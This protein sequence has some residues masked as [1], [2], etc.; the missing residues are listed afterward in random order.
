MNNIENMDIVKRINKL[1]KEKNAVIL[2]H[3]YQPEEIQRIAD[4]IGDSLELCIKAE[5][6]DADIIVFCGVDFMAETAKILNE[7]KKVLM[8]EIKDT[9]CPMAHQ[10][11]PETIINAKTEH[12]NA[13]VV[14]YVNTLSSAKALADATCTSANADKIVNSFEEKEILFGPDQNLG[15]YVKKRTDKK[16]IGIPKDGHCYV[17]KKFTKED[18]LNMKKQ[19][20]NA[21]ILVHPEC[22]P[23][24]QDLADYVVSTGGMLNHV[25]NSDKEEFIIGTE[26]DMITRLNLELEK[27]GKTKILIPLRK[28]A[29]CEPM[30]QITLEKIERCLIEEE[31]EI[32][33]DKEIIKKAKKAIEYM[34]NV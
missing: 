29:I 34:L 24:V 6:T 31:Y 27:I 14:I 28:D 21:E 18:I 2:A 11:P 16:I 23:E 17:H 3:N 15:Y 10:I 5:E 20:P 22:N 1:K 19:H 30:K 9:E 12:P 26:C 25:L 4:F 7:N 32:K 8:P 13:K 33:L